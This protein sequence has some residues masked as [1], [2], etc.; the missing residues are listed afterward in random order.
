[1]QISSILN[2]LVQVWPIL[3]TPD[4]IFKIITLGVCKCHKKLSGIENGGV[5][6]KI[7][8]LALLVPD[9]TISSILIELVQV[10]PILEAQTPDFGTNN[11]FT[12]LKVS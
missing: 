12:R 11:H 7:M 4:P 9:M 2:T 5:E 1:M 10:W 6:L 3:E 8:D